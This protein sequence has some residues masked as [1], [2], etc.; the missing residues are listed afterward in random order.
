MIE[1]LYEFAKNFE[2]IQ[3]NQ[4]EE[5]EGNEE[6]LE[7]PN[8]LELVNTR[9]THEGKISFDGDDFRQHRKEIDDLFT[10]KKE[11]YEV[12]L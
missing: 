7:N 6:N 9:N 1:Y 5:E 4:D 11:K 10:G 8:D 3:E 12:R 2:N